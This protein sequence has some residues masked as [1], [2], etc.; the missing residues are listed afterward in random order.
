MEIE[1]TR[2]DIA[3]LREEVLIVPVFRTEKPHD[4][5]PESL[6]S[7]TRG[8]ITEAFAS[9]E[10]D[11]SDDQVL[12]LHRT[13]DLAA[14]RLLLYGAGDRESFTTAKLGQVAGAATRWVLGRGAKSM[15]FLAVS[16]DGPATA[17][18]Q[19]VVE[20]VIIGQASSDLYCT[21]A[22]K[23]ELERMVV[24]VDGGQP[25]AFEQAIETGRIMG[26]ATNLA[27][28]LGNEPSNVMTPAE[29]ARR[30]QAMAEREGLK[31][32]VFGEAELKRRG[33][34]AL[35]AV[36]SGSSEPPRFIILDYCP[37]QLEDADGE[38]IALV[39]KGVT[40]DSGGISIKP[41]TSMD[42][43][44][45]D[46][47]GGAAVIGAMQAIA[48]IK[49]RTRVLGIVAACEN[50]PSGRG[51]KPGDVVKGLG[52][53]TVEII[54]TDAEGR[55]ILADAI[56]YAAQRGATTIVDAATLTGSCVVAL[57]EIRAGIM[58]TDQRLIDDLIKAGSRCGERLWQ[59]P[60]DDRY[61]EQI[62]SVIADIKNDGGRGAGAITAAMFLKAFAGNTPWAHLD[63]AGTAWIND[64]NLFIAK[65]ATGFGVRLLA[66]FVIQRA[67]ARSPSG[68]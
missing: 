40:F 66:D 46:M 38:T 44:K 61:G 27:R 4:S 7:L 18:V 25:G 29:M 64:A 51:Y 58:G 21:G 3:T 37:A 49:P 14:R 43:M 31:A 42:E 9:G 10:F 16:A 56:A 47:C 59:L 52:S 41:A 65:G 26:E 11:G 24:A 53:K 32:E 1:L 34:G 54:N 5:L 13:G 55:V 23:R 60:L 28:D 50:M 33:F 39:G 15:A 20:G 12:F 68:H 63:I 19:H 48:R 2:Q 30:A 22:D 17:S 62:S 8:V 67:G 6:D 35:L 57:G 45:F 36:A